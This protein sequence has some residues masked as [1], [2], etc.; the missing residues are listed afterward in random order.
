[1]SELGVALVGSSGH[2]SRVAAPIVA[3]S[4]DARLVGVLG[5]A[6]GRSAGLAAHHPGARAFDTLEE[7]LAVPEVEALWIAAPNHLHAELAG[8]CLAAGRHV[9]LEKPMATRHADAVRLADAAERSD[10]CLRIGFQHR[11][12]AAHRW[13]RDAVRDGRLGE[14]RMVR[15]HRFWRFPYFPDMGT[16]SLESWRMS[17]ERSGGWILNDLGSHLLDLVIWLAGGEVSLCRA[18]TANLRFDVPVE[19]TAVLVLDLVGGGIG[20]IDMSNAVGSFPSVVEVHGT[21]GWARAEGTF[22][23]GGTIV[24]SDGEERSFAPEPPEEAYAAQ[25]A[26]FVRV[27]RGG[28]GDATD[29]RGGV[30]NVQIIQ[31][32]VATGR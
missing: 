31:A 12:R 19:D 15:V 14:L 24:T 18:R 29:P 22:E 20:I 16:E 11:F 6:P 28:G 8:D 4:A 3:A 7:L 25:L 30:R 32:A 9:L 5:G 17:P 26:D 13:L 10:A 1:M 21:T 23:D 27:A 2:A